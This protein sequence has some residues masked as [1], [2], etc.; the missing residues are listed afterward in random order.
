MLAHKS[1]RMI[2]APITSGRMPKNG[3]CIAVYFALGLCPRRTKDEIIRSVVKGSPFRNQ[4]GQSLG[5]RPGRSNQGP[6][7]PARAA[8]KRRNNSFGCE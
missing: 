3:A 1:F 2:A 8:K 4:A 7:R 6:H 5:G